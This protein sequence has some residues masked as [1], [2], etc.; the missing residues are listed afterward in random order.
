MY[1]YLALSSLRGLHFLL[2][3]PQQSRKTLCWVQITC[4]LQSTMCF[5]NVHQPFLDTCVQSILLG[6]TGFVRPGLWPQ[7]AHQSV[8]IPDGPFIHPCFQQTKLQGLVL[9]R[10]QLELDV[11]LLNKATIGWHSHPYA[12][13]VAQL[14]VIHHEEAVP[15][16]WQS[17]HWRA[18]RKEGGPPIR[19]HRYSSVG[20]DSEAQGCNFFFCFFL[21]KMPMSIKFSLL[22][23]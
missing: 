4:S 3:T 8:W 20:K 13:V 1:K 22:L 6:L 2:N 7:G 12:R 9:W 23:I 18:N 15:H 16:A 5:Q 19:H 17:L 10:C 14:S 21:S 11:N